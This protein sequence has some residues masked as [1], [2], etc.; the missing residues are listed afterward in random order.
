M[1]APGT[2]PSPPPPP[3]SPP[4][5]TQG[6]ATCNSCSGVA[7]CCQMGGDAGAVCSDGQAS[8]Y[9]LTDYTCAC[10]PPFV[11][12]PTT[13]FFWC[14]DSS[15]PFLSLPAQVVAYDTN[16]YDLG[17]DSVCTLPAPPGCVQVSFSFNA[18]DDLGNDLTSLVSCS[19]WTD[20]YAWG[21]TSVTCGVPDQA[22]M[23]NYTTA[24]IMVIVYGMDA[25]SGPTVTAAKSSGAVNAQLA[26]DGNND[27]AIA[28]GSCT[29]TD[30]QSDPWFQVNLGSVQQVYFVAVFRPDAFLAQTYDVL[31]GNATA[32]SDPSNVLCAPGD[33]LFPDTTDNS[34]DI[35]VH[36]EYVR[37]CNIWGQY[38]YLHAPGVVP[39][40]L[41]VCEITVY[42]PGHLQD[43]TSR[44]GAPFFTCSAANVIIL[45]RALGAAGLDKDPAAA[46]AA[47]LPRLTARQQEL[48]LRVAA[49]V[50]IYV[51]AF[52]TRLF[53]I[54]RHE[55]VIHEFDPYFNY[56][57]TV[58]LVREGLTKFWNWFDAETWYPLGRIVGGTLYPGLMVT[59]AAEYWLLQ[60]LR[61][62]VHLRDVCVLTPCFFAS[63]TTVVAYFLGKEV[64]D[65][66]TG[67]LA[68]AMLGICPGYIS[69]SV[70]GSFDYEG[71]AIFALLLMFLFFIK[72][73]KTG[74][75]AWTV[76]AAFAYFYMASS[77]GGYIFIINLLPI[78]V[79]VLLV[80]G[81]YT[82][83]LYVAYCA[84]YILGSLLAMQIRFI[85]FQHVQSGEHMAALGVFLLLQVFFFVHFVRH[86]LAEP[87]LFAAFL[88]ATVVSALTVG[89][90]GLGIGLLTGYISP[91]TGRFYSLL[92]PTY[93]KAHIPIIASVSE[94]QPTSWSSFFFD[95]Q[96]Y[97]PFAGLYFCFQN[98][99]E[100][101]VFLLVYALT[102]LYFAG[103]MVRLI[104]VATP[105]V[106]VVAAVAASASLKNFCRVLW[107]RPPEKAAG[108]AA[109]RGS[110]A[111][112]QAKSGVDQPLPMQREAAALAV[113]GLLY[114]LFR[115]TV[116]CTWVTAEAYSSPSIVLSARQANGGKVI[117]DDFREGYQW[118]AHNTPRDAKVM[119]WW[120]YGY[121]ISAMANRTVIVDNNTWNNTHIATVGRAMASREVDAVKI[122]RS[123][124]VSYVLVVFGGVTGYS[125]DD[126]NKFLWMVR[127]GA[128]VFPQ[129]RE[130]EY[131][132]PTGDYR[133]DALATP[134]MVDCLM[135]KM[136]YYRFGELLSENGRPTGWDRARGCEIGRK[137]FELE[138][139]EEAFTSQ[140]W[141]VRIYRVK[142][143]ENRW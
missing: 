20:S 43:L 100:A 114:I 37:T 106:C 88:R 133:V 3:G 66:G 138:H 57:T 52:A 96:P 78:Y 132:T 116:H 32:Y 80:S 82:Q 125:S 56:R 141:I 25:F 48:L 69:R 124:D 142:E 101:T 84:V 90:L 76:A 93:A 34:G 17:N 105:A 19:V 127:I 23:S 99:T 55:S 42:T 21:I 13:G 53:S 128:G 46:L 45:Q 35:V 73:V 91:W 119:S 4:P 28:D 77:W 8:L 38:V 54:V 27:T 49:L 9:D 95:L 47:R 11:Y 61:I 36:N 1:A 58:Y 86:K 92:D 113:L 67:L 140:N 5:P 102:S 65:P 87:K 120:D 22:T 7:N 62:G 31:V 60:A 112:A 126:I 64:R 71:I 10:T 50:L 26:V 98:L 118:L 40:Q 70:A 29:Q 81:R 109:A 136:C 110:Y 59:A 83:R 51:L 33:Q 129:V 123:L 107:E 131:L 24:T 44:P 16:V 2:V 39:S 108:T 85:G 12:D 137:D 79:L 139:I 41:S 14:V 135:Y 63:N 97:A 122:M 94:H 15:A 115:F 111:K 104:L 121:Q 75:L 143:P 134:L 117:F 72:A 74:S 103:V 68:A 6:V 130:E 30:V 89:G 18:T